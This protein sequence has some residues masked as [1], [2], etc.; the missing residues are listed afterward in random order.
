MTIYAG[1]APAL[2][3]RN[4]L[5]VPA[6][7]GSTF[8]AAFGEAFS[9][10]PT[11]SSVRM[12]SLAT[13]EEGRAVVMGP[14]SYLGPNAGRQE[15]ETPILDAQSARDRVDSL[16]LKL[17]IPDQGI[18]QGA[19]DILIQRQQEQLARQQVIARSPGTFGTQ[20]AAGLGASLLDPINIAS[21][22]VPVVGEARYAQ[23]LGRAATPLARAGVR[24][25]VGALEGAVGAAIV[26]PLPLLAARQD[27]TDYD[28]SDSLANIAFG[29][30]LGGGLHSIGGAAS[31]ALKRRMATPDAVR[32]ES[33]PGSVS[34]SQVVSAP[35]SRQISIADFNRALDRDPIEAIQ[36][37]FAKQL[38][39]DQITLRSNAE[40]QA[41]DEIRPTLDTSRVSN[42]ADLKAQRLTLA[43]ALDTIDSTYRDRAKAFQAQG[44]SRK[45]AERATR[46]AI[47]QEK[48]QIGAQLSGVDSAL[49]K[50]RAGEFNRA[51]ISALDRGQIPE[52]LKPL[53][54]Q[55]VSQ[56]M[57]GYQQRPLG[58][59]IKTAREQ[60]TDA[61]WTVRES[62][63]KSA[64]AQ[65]VTGRDIDVQNIF[66]LGDP[67]KAAQALD[68]LQ[69]PASPRV[70]PEGRIESAR[71]S[72]LA[73]SRADEFKAAQEEF[74]AEQALSKEMLDQLP[75]EDRALVER[76]SAGELAEAAEAQAKADQY[77][78]AYR[79]AALCDLRNRA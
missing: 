67:A 68:A 13:Q 17:K 55:R 51:D 73:E 7:S 43:D 4:I 71:A 44:M 48:D 76:E 59:A 6:D 9:T 66:D 22:F 31:D 3:R 57:Q 30:I 50:N 42:V 77:S 56:I 27:Q 33:A 1:D 45:Q 19:L 20:I 41:I 18:R 11:T 15:P 60:A 25:G 78:K 64:V 40:R 54:D 14:E 63:L 28:L 2:D 53:I 21:A 8:D 69:R 39:D 26:E 32:V 36:G 10:N 58:A 38:Q 70:D 35:E 49:E 65:A 74:D 72:N 5:D 16:G 46:D 24:G 75:P 62:A 12:E 37:A 29:G 47:A 23:L 34:P 61:D 79:A 52:R